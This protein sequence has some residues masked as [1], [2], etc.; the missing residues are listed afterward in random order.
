MTAIDYEAEYDNR[1][2]VPDHTGIVDRWDRDAEAYRRAARQARRADLGLSY[3]TTERQT[4]DLFRPAAGETDALAVFIHGGYWR[5]REPSTF[6][7]MARG[8]NQHGMTVA[9]VGYDL[10]PRVR[11]VDIVR[12]ARQA[13]LF[14]WWRFGQRM[15]VTG[16][17]AGAH[18]AACMVAT[19]W[20]EIDASAPPDLIPAGL[21]ISGVFDL[22]P[23]VDISVNADLCLTADEARKVSPIHWPVDAARAIDIVVGGAESSEFRRQSRILANAWRERGV[24]VNF[25]EAAGANHFT[26]LDPLADPLSEMVARAVALA[27]R[28]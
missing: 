26:V 11:I 3:G 1:A 16:H 2:L 23:L 10:C 18:L 28:L 19:D 8:L 4:I 22:A 15:L 13:C 7:H 9:V 6:S 27:G 12:Q 20:S 24:D 14:L 17:S 21:A 5:S 25:S